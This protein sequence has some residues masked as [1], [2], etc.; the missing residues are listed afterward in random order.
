MLLTGS[1]AG[2]S[3]VKT[4]WHLSF[5][6]LEFSDMPTENLP[7]TSMLNSNTHSYPL[8]P[9]CLRG[10][11]SGR[12]AKTSTSFLVVYKK[13]KDDLMTPYDLKL[14]CTIQCMCFGKE[15]MS[16][17]RVS[18]KCCFVMTRII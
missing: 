11:L 2:D 4:K 3:A 12:K 10:T 6:F 17:V 13:C 8:L 7:A 1:M 5:R 16:Y 14:L 18:M 15:A 9:G